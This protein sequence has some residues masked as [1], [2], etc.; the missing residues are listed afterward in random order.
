MHVYVNLFNNNDGIAMYMEQNN[1]FKIALSNNIGMKELKYKRLKSFN[2]WDQN[3]NMF[4]ALVSNADSVNEVVDYLRNIRVDSIKSDYA[5]MVGIIIESKYADA[6]L[7]EDVQSR[8][9]DNGYGFPKF[10]QHSINRK[11]GA[12]KRMHRIS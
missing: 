10:E 7:D 2:D 3:R 5:E 6:L 1:D 9:K 11:I 12:L 4:T 8:I